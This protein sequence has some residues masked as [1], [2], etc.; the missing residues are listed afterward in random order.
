[1]GA[2][3]IESKTTNATSFVEEVKDMMSLDARELDARY[4]RSPAHERL[5]EAV[6]TVVHAAYQ[7]GDSASE[8]AIHYALYKTYLCQTLGCAA[9]AK[10]PEG[11]STLA[12]IR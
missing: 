11:S 12:I 6:A 4:Q 9:G 8:W 7:E 3:V 2:T 5:L 10:T 1:M